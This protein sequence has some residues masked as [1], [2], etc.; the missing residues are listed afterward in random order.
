MKKTNAVSYATK[1]RAALM[2]VSTESGS[3]FI[4]EK[5]KELRRLARE[6][7]REGARDHTRGRP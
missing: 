4:D 3:A 2:P 5:I 6:D 7:A 1:P